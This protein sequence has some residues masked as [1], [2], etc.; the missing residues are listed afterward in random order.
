MVISVNSGRRLILQ[1]RYAEASAAA[2]QLFEQH[3]SDRAAEQA[4]EL[5]LVFAAISRGGLDVELEQEPKQP[6]LEPEFIRWLRKRFPTLSPE[7]A[8]A[9]VE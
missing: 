9:P 5:Y 1:R 7:Q 2:K 4:L 6:S 8:L 3:E